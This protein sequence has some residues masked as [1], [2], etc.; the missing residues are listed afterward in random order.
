MKQSTDHIFLVRP[1]NFGFNKE[2]STSNAFQNNLDLTQKEIRENVL[3]EFDNYIAKLKEVGVDV[4][5]IEDTKY[6]IKPDAVFPNNWGSFHADGTIILY[7]M[8]A[9]NRRVEKR[10]DIIEDFKRNYKVKNVIDLS[11]YE[12]EGKFCEGTGSI[13]FDHINKIAY[14]CL[15]SRTDNGIFSEVCNLINYKPICF[16]SKDADG[17]EIYHTNVMMCVSEKFAVVCLES[18]INEDEK[19]LVVTSLI[20][21]GHEIVDITFEQVCHFAGNMLSVYNHSGKEFLVMSQSAFNVLSTKQKDVLQN[22]S[23]LLPVNIGTIEKIGG[24]SV[25]CM[26]SEIFLPEN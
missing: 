22:Y 18:I 15:S 25:R 6:P 9:L 3:C 19:N 16:T 11:K 20:E 24:G 23:Q 14:A 21:T 2:T 10:D 13:I 1:A 7:P 12:Q 4:T 26:I 5:V 8:E 17:K